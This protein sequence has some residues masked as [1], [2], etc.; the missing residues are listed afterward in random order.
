[1]SD[2]DLLEEFIA[3]IEALRRTCSLEEAAAKVARIS[4]NPDIAAA[5]AARL[6]E[7]AAAYGRLRDPAV[8]ERSDLERWYAG[9][10]SND[11]YW[12]P[13]RDYIA[14]KWRNEAAVVEL[15]TASTRIVTDFGN[16]HD[17]PFSY[18]GLVAGDVQSGKTT[19]FTAVIAKA[20][21]AGY[22]MFIILSGTKNKL[23]QQTQK[24]IDSD[25]V[26]RDA[27]QW[28]CLT[29]SN[30]DFSQE[31][32]AKAAQVL[33][34]AGDQ[35][36][37]MVVKKN[38]RRLERLN[39][40]LRH[41]PEALLARTPT[42]VVDDEADE[43]SI[44]TKKA[45]EQRAAVNRGILDLLKV[46][47][48]ATFVGY[49]ATPYANFMIDAANYED[50]YP[51]D[52]IVTL[53]SGADY[54]GYERIFGRERT[55][56][57]ESDEDIDGL[58]MIR[59]VSDDEAKEL[60]AAASGTGASLIDPSRTPALVQSIDWFL[61][62]TAARL[63]RGQRGEHSSML[64]HTSQRVATHKLFERPIQGWCEALRS[65]IVNGQKAVR[66][67]LQELWTTECSKVPAGDFGRSPESFDQ[68]WALLPDVLKR[69]KVVV[70]NS[71]TPQ[72]ERLVYGDDPGIFVVIG[73]DVLSRGL[74]LE[75]LVCSFFTRSASTFDTLMQMGRWFGYRRG[76]EDLPRMWMTD[77]LKSSFYEMGGIDRE[78][79]QFIERSYN[80]TVTPLDFAPV[81]RRHPRLAITSRMKMQGPVTQFKYS[82]ANRRLQ[83]IL[84]NHRNKEWLR[85]N[86]RATA[87]LVDEARDAGC[88]FR[89]D[90]RSGSTVIRKVPA[91]FVAQFLAS[92]EFHEQSV[93]LNR[94]AL[95]DY[96][97]AERKAGS[98]EEWSV[99]VVSG[100]AEGK[101][102]AVSLAR[103]LSV[104]AVVRSRISTTSGYANIKSLMSQDDAAADLDSSGAGQGSFE[105]VIRRRNASLPGVGLLVL[106]PIDRL[107]PPKA[108]G[109]RAPLDAVDTVIGVGLVFPEGKS[110]GTG[111]TYYQLQLPPIEVEAPDEDEEE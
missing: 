42:L 58:D 63:V 36:I 105:D 12:P 33:I 79:R 17:A 13:V 34:R 18:R 55:K 37:L 16:P 101:G 44:N 83:T 68:V 98:L 20:A 64:I 29:D 85:N 110:G 71:M 47:P 106:Y 57:D 10:G 1:M 74:T 99:V 66:A 94:R 69:L 3:H 8:I 72:L 41:A 75:G 31:G 39:E 88:V 26:E 76:F 14:G 4:R 27:T 30:N 82:Y 89:T 77:E 28:F 62:A 104:R 100:G 102:E 97:A 81:I 38:A 109:V 61:L 96:L 15:D 56:F 92:Y 84:F 49:T 87:A 51:R 54:F 9:P 23:R 11:V 43:A 19:N 52:F 78:M 95:L 40:W 5:A 48:K 91:D 21:D 24:R 90:E 111:D 60:K 35:P 103:N 7:R 45:K 93:D 80:G 53:R 73:G 22:R 25:L 50:L 70:E 107:S 46:L 67:R 6:R 86:L 2:E 65:S 32:R 108:P 59:S